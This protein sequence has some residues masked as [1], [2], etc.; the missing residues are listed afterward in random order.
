MNTD[1]PRW[2]AR[3]IFTV[4]IVGFLSAM[5]M[6]LKL[7]GGRIAAWLREKGGWS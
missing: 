5:V 7:L 6:M 1:G 2:A 3:V 4:Y